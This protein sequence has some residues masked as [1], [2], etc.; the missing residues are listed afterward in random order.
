MPNGVLQPHITQY[1]LGAWYI[2][3]EDREFSESGPD[4]WEHLVYP[5]YMP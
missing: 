5:E 1:E 4:Y 3:Y 2:D